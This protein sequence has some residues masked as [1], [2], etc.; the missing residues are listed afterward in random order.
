MTTSPSV[1]LAATGHATSL[2]LALTYVV[3]VTFDLVLPQY[4]MYEA[5]QPFLPG[6]A[7]LTWPSFLLG[8]AE[9]YAY[10]WY[11]ALVW[12]PLYNVFSRRGRVTKS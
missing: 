8:L 3:C 7:W 11:I 10:G 2:L 4:A 6:F 1:S 5:W 9:T 12:V